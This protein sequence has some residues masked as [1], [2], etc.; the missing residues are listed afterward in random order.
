MCSWRSRFARVEPYQHT[1]NH[2]AGTGKTSLLNRYIKGTFNPATTPSTVGASFS[3]KR[4]LDIDS[5]VTVRLQLWDTAGQERFRSISRLYYRG[6]SAVILVYSILDPA[7]FQEMG[8]WLS[9]IRDHIGD[10]VVI[11]VVGTKSD[12]A[13][14]RKV[15]FEK[16]VEFITESLYPQR[17]PTPPIAAHRLSGITGID[18]KRSSGF[19]GQDVGWDCKYTAPGRHPSPISYQGICIMALL[20]H[21]SP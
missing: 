21:I 9:E 18:S 7:S 17:A 12:V 13:E 19:W 10:D 15:P 16:C 8:R 14:D 1:I 11:H 20:T 2:C 5:G 3:T 6:A 4:V